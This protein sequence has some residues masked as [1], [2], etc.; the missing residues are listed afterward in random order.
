MLSWVVEEHCIYV[1]PILPKHVINQSVL[2]AEYLFLLHLPN[3]FPL[4]EK[5]VSCNKEVIET[6]KSL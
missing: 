5:G 4:K 2:N 1:A 3:D 6:F